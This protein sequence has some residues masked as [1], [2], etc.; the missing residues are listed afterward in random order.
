MKKVIQLASLIFLVTLIT[1]CNDD[2][3]DITPLKKDK[4]TG[5]AQKG[6]FNNG[7]SVLIS[8]LNS[9][10]VQTGKNIT[11]NIK[12]NQGLYE[13]DNIEFISQYVILTVNGFYFNEISG[14]N[15]SAQLTLYAITD[16]SDKNNLNINVLSSIE[17]KRVEFLI[18]EGLTFN[19]A[20]NQAIQEILGIFEID[21]TLNLESETLDIS[22]N[23]EGNSILLAISSMLQGYRTTA[24]LSLLLANLSTDLETDGTLDDLSIKSDLIIHAKSLN[25]ASIKDNL[26]EYYESLA[27][28][29]SIPDFELH[30]QNFIQN[31]NYEPNII[32]YPENGIYGRNILFLPEAADTF[33][34][35]Q[36]YSLAAN[37][38]ENGAI[39]IVIKNGS[40]MFQGSSSIN[41]NISDYDN[42]NRT[43]TFTSSQTGQNCDLRIIFLTDSLN[44][45]NIEI[46]YYEFNSKYPTQVKQI[47]TRDR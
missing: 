21:T 6:P 18:S 33:I 22:K 39:K 10:F 46:E 28:E 24:D 23:S 25:L 38:P 1:S 32:E 35:E 36:D 45:N 9:D 29:Y 31:T 34:T 15:S 41:W 7:T 8:E 43:Q 27:I 30:I 26:E 2:N 44:I 37:L 14:N 42:T 20:K 11:S 13:I 5:F 19:D 4:I 40:W 3:S 16:L 17:K 47:W 12:N